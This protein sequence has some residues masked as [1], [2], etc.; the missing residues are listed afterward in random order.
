MLPAVVSTNEGDGAA[1]VSYFD[2]SLNTVDVAIAVGCCFDVPM[3]F[4]ETAMFVNVWTS[5]DD[6]SMDI[7]FD[8]VS[9][10]RVD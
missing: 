3:E 9:W 10:A 1:V 2:D 6:A 4:I 7:W 8:V 5:V